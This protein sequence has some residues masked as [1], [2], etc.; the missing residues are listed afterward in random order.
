M[1]RMTL[2][3]AAL[4][5]L[6]ISAALGVA[7][8]DTDNRPSATNQNPSNQNSVNQ[9]P[10]NQ[11]PSNQNPSNQNPSN[12]NPSGTRIGATDKTFLIDATKVNTALADFGQIAA[13]HGGSP[14]VVRFGQQEASDHGRIDKDL[15]QVA[16]RKDVMVPQEMDAKD[17]QFRDRLMA[18]AQRTGTEFDREYL[19]R[20]IQD[21][22]KDIEQFQREI[23]NGKDSDVQ[24]WATQNLSMLQDHLRNA[25]TILDNLKKKQTAGR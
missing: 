6:G 4:L 15:R 23:K 19:R 2:I 9:N 24:S 8:A 10:S 16:A 22:E 5:V 20:A 3:G 21:H 13:E 17:K 7:T 12:Q 1:K 18:T 25:R 14:E 11:N